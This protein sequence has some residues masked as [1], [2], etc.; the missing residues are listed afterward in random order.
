MAMQSQ[1]SSLEGE[2]SFPLGSPKPVGLTLC[3]DTV[4]PALVFMFYELALHPNQAEKLN[5]ELQT[6]DISDRKALQAL[7]HLNGFINECLRLHPPV[8]SGGYRETPPEGMTVAGHY[9][10][11]NTTIVAPRYSLGRREH[12]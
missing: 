4:A 3:S 7:P 12:A 11:G 6:T 9:I 2:K 8:P 5:V 10:P 1:S